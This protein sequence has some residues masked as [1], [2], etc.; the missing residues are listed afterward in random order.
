MTVI[1]YNRLCVDGD[2]ENFK[3]RVYIGTPRGW[4]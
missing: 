2:M 3:T 4:S 1:I